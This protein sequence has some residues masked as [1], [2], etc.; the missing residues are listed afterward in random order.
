MQIF[1]LE[2]IECY[3][4]CT[5]NISSDYVDEL[6]GTVAN[7]SIRI[8]TTYIHNLKLCSHNKRKPIRMKKYVDFYRDAKKKLTYKPPPWRVDQSKKNQM[9]TS[10]C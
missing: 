5:L 10:Y 6:I 3:V 7:T 2:M 9:D 1:Q 8:G 4:N